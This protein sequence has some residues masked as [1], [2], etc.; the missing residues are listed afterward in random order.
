MD[1]QVRITVA[2]QVS[3]ISCCVDTFSFTGVRV[4]DSL[5]YEVVEIN[6]GEST[7]SDGEK[8]KHDSGHAKMTAVKMNDSKEDENIKQVTGNFTYTT[9]PVQQKRC[10]SRSNIIE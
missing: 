10:D 7:L 5:E 2:R 1:K 6:S 3:G 8:K 9:Q 4:K